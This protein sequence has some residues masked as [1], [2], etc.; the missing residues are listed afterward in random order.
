M[1]DKLAKEVLELTGGDDP[2]EALREIKEEEAFRVECEKYRFYEPNGKAEEFIAKVGSGENFIT[3]FSAANG[4]G[5][6]AAGANIVAH[7]LFGADS[8]NPYFDYPL[9][10]KWPYPKRGRIA[11][12]PTNIQKNL[13]PTLKDWFP[14]GRFTTYKGDKH[15]DSMWKTDTG[16]E[17]DIMTYEQDVKEF[18]GSTLGWAWFDEPVPEVIFKATV[19]RMRKGGIIF[20]TATPLSGSGWMYDAFVIASELSHIYENEESAVEQG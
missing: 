15:Y 19:A 1:P 13:I 16:W 3:L 5:K 14:E 2:M 17:F 9:Y 7:L 18:E 10:K 4:V 6:T 12:D 20:I 8:E 11:S